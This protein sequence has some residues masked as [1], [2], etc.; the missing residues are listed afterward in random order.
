M[1]VD[2][3]FNNRYVPIYVYTRRGIVHTSDCKI[4]D[5]NWESLC[6]ILRS[7]FEYNDIT[8]GIEVFG[9]DGMD[10]TCTRGINFN[11]ISVY[12][13]AGGEE[14]VGLEDLPVNPC[15]RYLHDIVKSNLQQKTGYDLIRFRVTRY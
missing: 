15:W 12:I 5:P 8:I 11:L 13:D 7:Q 6:D 10:E 9:M 14:P 1:E 4:F 3:D 2:N